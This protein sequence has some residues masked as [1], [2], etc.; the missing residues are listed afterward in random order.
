MRKEETSKQNKIR[1]EKQYVQDGTLTSKAYKRVSSLKSK[2]NVQ[3][4]LPRNSS[5]LVA[6]TLQEELRQVPQIFCIS[7]AQSKKNQM[8]QSCSTLKAR[9]M[10]KSQQ[11]VPPSFSTLKAQVVQEQV[12][13][14]PMNTSTVVAQVLEK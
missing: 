11:Y 7:K 5:T 6:Q 14:A 8:P 2:E 4:I 10:Q 12:Q 1:K 9:S 13:Q 3:S